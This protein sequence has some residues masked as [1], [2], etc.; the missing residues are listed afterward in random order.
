MKN[1]QIHRLR[2]ACVLIASLA[3]LSSCGGGGS[4]G[5][6]GSSDYTIGGT[7][8]G[9]SS[10][11]LVLANGSDTLKVLANATSFTMPTAVTN[12]TA[13]D[14]TVQA[15]PLAFSC[16]VISGAGS[17]T[18]ADVTSIAVSCQ[19]GTESV[20]HSF[21]GPPTDGREPYGSLIQASDGNFYGM[22]NLGGASNLGTVF[23][24]TPGGTETVLH[25]FQGAPTDGA[26]P[27]GSL[28]QGSDGNFYG[29]TSAGG[30]S[31]NGVVFKI[32]PGGTE[33]VLHSFQGNPTDGAAP[34]GSL[35]QASDG[36]FYGTTYFGGAN[37]S[38]AV[39]KITSGGIETVLYSF[40]NSFSGF[41]YPY[42]GLIQGSDGNLY[43]MTSAGGPA[44]F[45]VVFEITTG[46][47]ATG[48]HTFLG[49]PTDGAYPLGNLIQGSGNNLFGM[50]TEGGA[51]S[52]GVVFEIN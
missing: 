38:G 15:H 3:V 50:T 28:I 42:G 37:G 10:S 52:D 1:H 17:V 33:T 39:F 11:G 46:G 29:V 4:S 48:L 43:G 36:N 35:V 21:S 32:T 40:D 41:G 30:T 12:G 22:T 19:S 8:Q 5:S 13:Y 31:N 18:S 7:I 14:V 9:L 47:T 24:I 27:L 26:S 25:S 16:T 51:S 20:L 6:S 34:R 45:G 23:E 49:A 44:N 2:R